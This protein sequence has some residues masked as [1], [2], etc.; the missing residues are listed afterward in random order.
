MSCSWSNRNPIVANLLNPAFCGHVILSTVQSFEEKSE[1]EFPFLLVYLILPIL[2]HEKTREKMP[3]SART[4]LFKWIEEN[5]DILFLFPHRAKNMVKYT[6]EAVK[7]L[8]AHKMINFNEDGSIHVIHA[9]NIKQASSPECVEIM[10]KAKLL[11]KWFAL[12]DDVKT[13]Y[14]FFK[15]RP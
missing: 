12:S 2:L 13:V 7:F 6:K 3:R 8:V 5:D 15:I 1:K 4:Y 9:K 10:K 11:G 14:S